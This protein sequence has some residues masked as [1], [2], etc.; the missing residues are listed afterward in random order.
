MAI[1]RTDDTHYQQ[2]A[3]TIRAWTQTEETYR[4]EDMWVGVEEV[5]WA[6]YQAGQ[7][8]GG[9]SYE[10]GY[11]Q[12]KID[13]DTLKYA[14]TL[15]SHF[16]N[17][18]FPDGYEITVDAPN[19][20]NNISYLFRAATGVRKVT[21]NIPTDKDYNVSN[22]IY[23][24][25][26]EEL[27]LPDGIRFALN[28]YFATNSKV[29]RSVYGRI[30]LS[31]SPSNAGLFNGCTA[32]VDAEFVPNT[33]KSVFTIAHSPDLSDKTRQSIVD[34][35]ADMTGQTS[36]TLTVHPT[37]GAKFTDTQRAT[38]TAKNVTLVY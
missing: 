6:G 35:Y 28:N 11:E 36:P 25:T 17:S 4:P 22:F 8:E 14:S 32:L 19:V 26:V 10:E 23:Q 27:V 7:A 15:T 37:V 30:D 33:I 9:G 20:T 34:G 38:L 1:V 16:Q 29:L 31:A 24:S 5:Y 21:M 13:G 18:V 3:E 12:G 2:I